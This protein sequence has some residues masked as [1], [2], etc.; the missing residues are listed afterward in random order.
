[1]S[2]AIY[3]GRSGITPRKGGRGGGEGVNQLWMSETQTF[4]NRSIEN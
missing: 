2:G 1:M 4:P 3:K